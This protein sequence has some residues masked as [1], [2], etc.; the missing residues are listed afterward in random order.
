MR[1]VSEEEA[2][3]RNANELAEDHNHAR[4]HSGRDGASGVPVRPPWE[5][6]GTAILDPASAYKFE[7]YD[8]RHDWTQYTDVAAQ[9]PDK[10]RGM[11]DLMFA[12]QFMRPE[13]S[14]R[15]KIHAL[16]CEIVGALNG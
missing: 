1:L 13:L 8:V 4:K 5:L 15:S 2:V 11:T 7:L 14:H 10:V 12:D 16:W 3:G 9:N 6:L